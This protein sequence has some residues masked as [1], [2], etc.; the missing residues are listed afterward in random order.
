VFQ[1]FTG[2]FGSSSLLPEVELAIA[3]SYVEEKAWDSAERAYNSWLERFGTNDQRPVV[4]FN[5][6]WI[7]Y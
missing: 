7:N 3:R 5:R 1:D 6:A 4:E 2:A